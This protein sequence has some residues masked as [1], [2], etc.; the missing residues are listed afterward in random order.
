MNNADDFAEAMTLEA[1]NYSLNKSCKA[2]VLLAGPICSGKLPIVESIRK[3]FRTVRSCDVTLIDQS[4]FYKPLSD[5]TPY[6]L[7]YNVDSLNA[8]YTDEIVKRVKTLFETGTTYSPYYDYE[9][10]VRGMPEF[11]KRCQNEEER[12]NLIF[13]CEHFAEHHDE[14]VNIFFGTHV[15]SLLDKVV[16]DNIKIFLDTDFELCMKRRMA[17][18]RYQRV[19]NIKR[20]AD[21]RAY[22]D[23]VWEENE[24]SVYPQKSMAQLVLQN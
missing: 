23:F 3:W 13:R 20:F 14:M 22:H 1:I 2:N 18:N 5:M 4:S 7:G 10:W 17:S 6:P 21:R 16:P 19:A 12:G 11:E 15:I 9:H 24:W 8:F